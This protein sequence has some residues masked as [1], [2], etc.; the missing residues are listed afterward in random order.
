[1]GEKGHHH[2]PPRNVLELCTH[3][4]HLR[5]A[6]LSFQRKTNE[7]LPSHALADAPGRQVTDYLPRCLD[8]ITTGDV[9]RAVERY[10][11][12]GVVRYL[13]VKEADCA[14]RTIPD[15]CWK[16]VMQ[17]AGGHAVASR[18]INDPSL[19]TC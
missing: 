15:T 19:V 16:Q 18:V 13:T 14:A 4:V 2:P 3:V 17:S 8:M 9:I 1:M 5:D 7:A 11:E 10:F 6:S 12:G